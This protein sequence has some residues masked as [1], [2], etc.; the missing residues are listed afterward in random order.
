[1]MG[2]IE[3]TK[4]VNPLE[5]EYR[6]ASDFL[7]SGYFDCPISDFK[8]NQIYYV[9]KINDEVIAARKVLTELNE[10]YE[11][12][13]W[14][15]RLKNHIDPNRPAV[16]LQALAVKKEFRNKGIG[17]LILKRTLEDISEDVQ[18]FCSLCSSNTISDKYFNDYGFNEI[19]RMPNRVVIA[20]GLK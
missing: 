4:M 15:E 18:I 10:Y 20:K 7:N 9:V 19:L 3:I 17:E 14:K 5:N 11:D 1:M 16:Y 8:F 13:K 2:S 12:T 6:E